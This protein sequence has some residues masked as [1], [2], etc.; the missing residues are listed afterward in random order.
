MCHCLDRE[1]DIN[2]SLGTSPASNQTRSDRWTDINRH[3]AKDPM[4]VAVQYTYV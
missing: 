2:R 3:D 4:S 1:L